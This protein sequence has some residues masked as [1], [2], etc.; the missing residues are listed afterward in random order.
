MKKN[1][2]TNRICNQLILSCLLSGLVFSSQ[3]SIEEIKTN[4][5]ANYQKIEDYSVKVKIK[6]KMPG[7]RMPR[8]KLKLFYK[9]PDKI[10]VET[11]GF[12]LVPKSGL[13]GS[14]LKYLNKLLSIKY[15]GETELNERKHF[16]LNGPILPDSLD[17]DIGNSENFP[18]VKM[19][20]WIDAETWMLSKIE[21]QLD[22][23]P[24][25]TIQNHYMEIDD[26]FLPKE[27]IIEMSL[28]S[29]KNWDFR[30]P[31]G[32]PAGDNR[33]FHDMVKELDNDKEFS[34]KMTIEFSKYKVNQGIDDSIFLTTESL[35]Q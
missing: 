19:Q 31:T 9:S 27:T 25:F 34:G 1:Y 11:R 15:L 28:E 7:L 5:F 24:V 21:T 4:L 3:P 8:K 33:A 16:V 10:K 35:S 23:L 6:L 20:F 12:A 17:F 13:G 29:L 22:T 26:I 32:G 2:F 30:N 18:V 14:P